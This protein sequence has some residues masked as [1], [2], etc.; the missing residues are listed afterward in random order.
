[1]TLERKLNTRLDQ[2]ISLWILKQEAMPQNRERVEERRVLM[3]CVDEPVKYLK[4]RTS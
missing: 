3:V 1:M 2:Q 4:K